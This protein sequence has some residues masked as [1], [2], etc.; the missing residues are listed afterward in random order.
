MA[1]STERR[2]QKIMDCL[3]EIADRY[4]MKINT[5]KTKIMKVSRKTGDKINITINGKKIEQVQSFKYLG[6]TLTEDGRCG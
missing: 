6:S 4:G 5:K 2:L 3:N 1:A